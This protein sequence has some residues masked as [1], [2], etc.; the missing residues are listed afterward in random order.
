[1]RVSRTRAAVC[2]CVDAMTAPARP[3]APFVG[4]DAIETV[5]GVWEQMLADHPRPDARPRL[6]HAGAMTPA[7]FERAARLGATIS[8]FVDHIY[9][10]GDVL[11]DDLFGPEHAAAWT[12]AASVAG[13]GIPFFFH[14]DVPVTPEEPLRNFSVAATRRSRSGRLLGPKERL[15]MDQALLGHGPHAAW[16]LFSE[17]EVGA[18]VAGRCA[19]VVVLSADPLAVEPEAVAGLHVVATFLGGRQVHGDLLR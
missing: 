5:L 2:D 8:L 6:E 15:P 9:Y 16:Q 1:M 18:L 10:W 4:D 13:A 19:D 7:Q 3:G 12:A 14:N 17:H 11:A